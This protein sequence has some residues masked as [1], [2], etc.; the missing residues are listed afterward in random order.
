MGGVV[1]NR[2]TDVSYAGANP[3][4][5]AMRWLAASGP[6]SRV[7]APVMHRLDR[8]V[9][10]LTRGRTTLGGLVSG[11]PVGLLTTTGGRT[12]RPRS[13]PLLV[14]PTSEGLAVIASNWGRPGP[15]AWERNLRA[16]PTATVSLFGTSFSS[17][18]VEAHGERREG[19]WREALGVYPGFAAYARRA[20][21]RR[22]GVYVLEDDAAAQ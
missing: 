10:R 13:V 1:A 19:I 12:G 7:F 3:V 4:R 6:G 20:G 2:W 11:L 9:Y 16:D 21:S 14:L 17:R 18:V 15:P 22:L 5:R 8:P